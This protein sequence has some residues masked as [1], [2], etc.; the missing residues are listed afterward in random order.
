MKWRI[1]GKDDLINFIDWYFRNIK[2]EASAK[3]IFEYIKEN[4]IY[5]Y[6]YKLSVLLISANLKNPNKFERIKE[7]VF[8][9]NSK[10]DHAVYTLPIYGKNKWHYKI[11]GKKMLKDFIKWYMENIESKTT[12]YRVFNYIQKEDLNSRNYSPSILTVMRIMKGMSDVYDT[13]D[14]ESIKSKQ[15]SKWRNVNYTVWALKEDKP[16][17]QYDDITKAVEEYGK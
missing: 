4:K 7:H 2:K 13:G 9:G 10:Y 14:K 16:S 1:E 12:S 11:V 6:D 3:D 17:L 15:K 8:K 5:S